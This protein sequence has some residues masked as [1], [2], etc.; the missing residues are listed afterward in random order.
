MQTTTERRPRSSDAPGG[1]DALAVLFE[2]HW[3]E[4][5]RFITSRRIRSS[6]YRGAVGELSQVQ[7]GALTI[8]ARDD[9]RMSDLAASLGLPEST[10]TRLVDRLEAAG[11]VKRGTS[12]PDRRCL[13]AGLTGSG[14]R[15]I[16]RARQDRQEFLKEILETLPDGERAE[17]VRLFGRMAAELRARYE[18]G[19]GS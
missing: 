7:L 14:R 16:Q 15:M 2:E 5:I 9:L 3:D 18:T 8:L 6:L 10:T 11:L 17:L 4:L 13:V 12:S 1:V 19:A